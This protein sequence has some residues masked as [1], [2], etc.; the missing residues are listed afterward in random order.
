MSLL[1]H[2]QSDDLASLEAGLDA[3]ETHDVD[4]TSAWR[5]ALSAVWPVAVFVGLLFYGLVWP[6][7]RRVRGSGSIS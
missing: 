3:L 7:R 1:D 2:R 4:R 5:R 6:L